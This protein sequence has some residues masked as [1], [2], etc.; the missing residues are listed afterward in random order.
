MK[1]LCLSMVIVLVLVA[2]SGCSLL[3][4]LLSPTGTVE[5]Y[6]IDATT[7]SGLAS[8]SVGVED[9]NSYSATTDSIG[10]FSIEA[11]TGTQVITFYLSGFDFDPITVVVVDSE[12]TSVSRGRIF[13]SPILTSGEYRFVLSWG[14][15]PSDLDSHMLTPGGEEIYYSAKIGTGLALDVDDTTAYGP[16]TITITTQQTGTYGYFVYNY[17]GSPGIATSGAVVKVYNS[18]GLMRSISIPTSGT[19][20][21]WKVASLNGSVLTVINTIVSSTPT[22]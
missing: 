19:G 21:Y 14:A 6:V 20:L 16:E 1:K 17:S 18:S 7:G 10:F 22:F 2:L 15:E 11:P 5:G 3:L 13:A 12:T 4:S 9:A 8:V